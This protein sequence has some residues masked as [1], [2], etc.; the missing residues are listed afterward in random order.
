MKGGGEKNRIASLPIW[1]GLIREEMGMLR[2]IIPPP[3]FDLFL[4]V[5]VVN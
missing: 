2:V 1:L 5:A 3:K 4:S